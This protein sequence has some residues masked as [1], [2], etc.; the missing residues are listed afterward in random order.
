M[1]VSSW[2]KDKSKTPK[3]NTTPWYQDFNPF[4]S[5]GTTRNNKHS[6]TLPDN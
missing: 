4:G 6:W 1:G 3:E 2:L 5:G